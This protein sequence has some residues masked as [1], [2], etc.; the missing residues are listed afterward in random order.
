MSREYHRTYGQKQLSR[1]YPRD[2][3]PCCCRVHTT[4]LERIIKGQEPG[5]GSLF[6]AQVIIGRY[7][8]LLSLLVHCTNPLV[9]SFTCFSA[10]TSPRAQET[11]LRCKENQQE[12]PTTHSPALNSKPTI[13]HFAHQ[14]NNGFP[15]ESTLIFIAPETGIVRLT[16]D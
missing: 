2:V 7:A 12:P 6:P 15:I 10:V 1:G 16:P 14:S 11:P 13:G 9:H 4:W 8:R 3:F 5:A